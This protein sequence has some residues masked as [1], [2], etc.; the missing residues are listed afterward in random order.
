MVTPD[1][2]VENAEMREVK[3]GARSG[4]QVAIESGLAEG[5]IVVVVGSVGD[6][7][8]GTASATGSAMA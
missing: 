3:V 8:T 4:S 6:D 5:E 7:L 2:K 1:G